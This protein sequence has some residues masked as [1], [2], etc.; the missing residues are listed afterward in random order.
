MAATIRP[1]DDDVL[2]VVDVQLDFCPDGALAVVDGD[3]VVPVINRLAG[4][5][6]H[7]VLTQDWHPPGHSSFASSHSGAEPFGTIRLA[8][9]EQ[10]LWP[11][12]CV[13]ETPGARF[14][15]ELAI[16][17]AELILRKGFRRAIDSYSAFYENDKM[18][19]TGLRGYLRERGFRR[20]F[21]AG[22]ALDFCVR[23]SVEDAHRADFETVLIDDACRPVDL[24]DSLSAAEQSFATLGITRMQSDEI[25]HAALTDQ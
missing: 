3:A 11:D 13:Q 17:H 25:G 20:V 12:H 6:D 2:L 18:T 15:P 9:G 24:A 8:Y 7:V 1:G 23:F 21:V 19:E 5:F 16:P 10:T 22:L 14:H 4:A